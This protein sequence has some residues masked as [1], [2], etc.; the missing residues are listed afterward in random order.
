VQRVQGAIVE[1]APGPASAREA[2]ETSG[3]FS[4]GS[5][6]MLSAFLRY[7]YPA[8]GLTLLLG[9]LGL[10]VPTGLATALAGSLAA[11]GHIDWRSASAIAVSASIVGDLIGY[12]IGYWLGQEFL[13]RRGRWIGYTP[14]RRA[15][16]Q[17]L[18]DRWGGPTVL[19]TRTL[20]SHLSS[21]VSLL[22]G[23]SRYRLAGFLAFAVLGR[24][25]WTSAY[26][27]LGYGVGHDLE[28]ATGFLGNFTGLLV[29]LA[30][31]AMSGL[32]ANGR[33]AARADNPG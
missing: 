15:R 12:A 13:D 20:V 4:L 10:P 8:F 28:A 29:C 23:I 2:G 11:Q 3:W 17:A 22:A 21:V 5:E 32:V 27:G 7:G 26:L 19:I 14:A 24:V 6:E 1:I 30:I 16:V 9:A 25:V 18:F 31:L 33:V